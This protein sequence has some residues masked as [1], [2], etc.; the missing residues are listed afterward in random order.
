MSIWCANV[1]FHHK[2][3]GVGVS[4]DP[5][6]S[7][8]L[9]IK[10]QPT[11]RLWSLCRILSMKEII[12]SARFVFPKEQDGMMR[13]GKGRRMPSF[14]VFRSAVRVAPFCVEGR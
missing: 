11:R 8:L 13:E 10:R 4:Q 7:K 1:A 5:A 6:A 3:K 9:F 12:G 14:T 2:P